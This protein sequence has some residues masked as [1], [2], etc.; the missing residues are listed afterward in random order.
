MRV[1]GV[2]G[3]SPARAFMEELCAN[4]G[5]Y[6]ARGAQFLWVDGSQETRWM[7]FK[8]KSRIPKGT[9]QEFLF[10]QANRFPHPGPPFQSALS[11]LNERL[12]Q[13]GAAW[14]PA[15]QA[16]NQA[17]KQSSNKATSQPA[18]RPAGRP[19]NQPTN[20]PTPACRS[21]FQGRPSAR[22]WRR[23]RVRGWRRR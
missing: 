22:P 4:L 7:C 10:L 20:Q 9:P 15:K 5:G 21:F 18:G 1:W 14:L 17:T 2:A 19:A 13:K 6:R 16:S 3:N 23:G 8:L 11:K 12:I